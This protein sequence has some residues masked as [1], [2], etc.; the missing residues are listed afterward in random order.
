[1]SRKTTPD[2]MGNLMYEKTC[3]IEPAIKEF[4]IDLDKEIEEEIEISIEPGIKKVK[5]ES[6]V[7]LHHPS[8]KNISTDT[9]PSV[10]QGLPRGWTRATFIICSE[11]NDKI[12]AIAYWDRVTV[13][14]VMHEALTAYLQDRKVRPIQKK[15]FI[16]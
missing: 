14:E 8:E 15:K 5:S 1:M 4:E 6:V 3:A 2:I 9:T 11:Y 16:A 13:K 7:T 12:K 10:Q